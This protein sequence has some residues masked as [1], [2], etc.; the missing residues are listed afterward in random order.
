MWLRVKV[1][2]VMSGG[3]LIVALNTN[4]ASTLDVDASDRVKVNFHGKDI[5]GLVDIAYGFVRQGEIGLFLEVASELDVKENDLVDVVIEQK[6]LS[7]VH[8]RNKM[9]RKALSREEMFEIVKDIVQN[10]LSEVEITYFVSACYIHKMSLEEV[11]YL[12]E[13]IVQFGGTLEF[14]KKPIVD[15]HSI[16]GI[17]GNRV[18]MVVVPIVAAAGL[19]I[20]KTSTRSIT[21]ASGTSDTM[22]LFAPVAHMKKK[23][24]EIV[25]A[26]NGCLVWGGTL[27]LASADDKL[28]KIERPLRLDPEGILLASI[29]AKKKAAGV[30]H[31]LLEIPIGAEMKVKDKAR[32]Q[33]LAKNFSALGK[34]LG[35]VFDF[36]VTD[37]AQPV[38]NGI[39]PALEARDVLMVLEGRGPEDLQERSLEFAARVLKMAGVKDGME[40]ARRILHSGLALTKFREIIKAQGGNPNVSVEDLKIGKFKHEMLARKSG[41]VKVVHTHVLAHLARMAGSPQDRGAGIA[42]RVKIGEK[43]KMGTLLFTVFAENEEKLKHAVNSLNG[44][45]PIEIS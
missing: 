33:H 16:G 22:E 7:I 19:T 28:I 32:A 15:V 41:K 35:I 20:P 1:V 10:K 5:I 12:T 8:I 24:E 40:K 13:A 34:K 17:P 21:S 37:G 25:K 27:D 26:T 30:T 44:T 14:K 4:D 36:M 11:S 29:T 9:E 43:V 38:G 2:N 3:P 18:S 45:H 23:I 42:M 6:P 31:V 39:G